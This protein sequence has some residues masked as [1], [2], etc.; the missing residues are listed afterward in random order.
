MLRV[1]QILGTAAVCLCFAG[2]KNK[3]SA[4]KAS[5]QLI[6]FEGS[7][8]CAKCIRFNDQVLAD[9]TFQAYMQGAGISLVRADFPQRRKLSLDE[10]RANAALAQKYGFQGTFP[11]VLLTDGT[12]TQVTIATMGNATTIMNAIRQNAEQW[13]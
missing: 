10:D 8:W 11:T 5:L 3:A 4:Q 6:V 12:G 2:L 9:S 7:D 13:H 1:W